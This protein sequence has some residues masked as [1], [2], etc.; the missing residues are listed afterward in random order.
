MQVN[1]LNYVGY[2]ANNNGVNGDVGYVFGYQNPSNFY[3]LQLSRRRIT[4]PITT[5]FEAVALPGIYIKAVKSETGPGGYLRNA[6]W[7]SR[8]I[9]GQVC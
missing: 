9:D 2:F 1:G 6:L 8:S 3:I 7:H 4:F 5:P